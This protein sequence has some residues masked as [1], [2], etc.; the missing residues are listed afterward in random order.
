MH[1][2]L[3]SFT[4]FPELLSGTEDKALEATS[5]D[6]RNRL[7]A[8]VGELHLSLVVWDKG[9]RRD[10]QMRRKRGSGARKVVKRQRWKKTEGGYGER[11]GARKGISMFEAKTKKWRR[12]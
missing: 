5:I 9:K 6:G 4:Q 1:R 3:S 12:D 10:T 7:R 8:F 2:L 11:A